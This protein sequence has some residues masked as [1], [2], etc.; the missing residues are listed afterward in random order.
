MNLRYILG[1]GFFFFFFLALV[2]FFFSSCGAA[3]DTV[4][5]TNAKP[6][7]T[8][9]DWV[10]SGATQRN[11]MGLVNRNWLPYQVTGDKV[12]HHV[13]AAWFQNIVSM[14]LVRSIMKVEGNRV[15]LRTTPFTRSGVHIVYEDLIWERMKPA[16][17]GQ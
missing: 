7:A 9:G 12:I 3:K 16:T 1:A 8:A 13:E 2:S 5:R 17:G 14:D 10:I 15:T 4:L 11:A 6:A